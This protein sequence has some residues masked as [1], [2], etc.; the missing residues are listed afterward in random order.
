M[1]DIYPDQIDYAS[2]PDGDVEALF[3]ASCSLLAELAKLWPD[4]KVA[5][6]AVAQAC[7]DL[8]ELVEHIV[9]KHPRK[10]APAAVPMSIRDYI[11]ELLGKSDE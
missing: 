7:G 1:Q 2:I 6:W 8:V 5:P 4:P 11:T 3:G 10:A 9:D